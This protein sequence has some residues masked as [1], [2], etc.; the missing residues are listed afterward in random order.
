[1]PERPQR[2]RKGAADFVPFDGQVVERR[3]TPGG[4][5]Y[6]RITLGTAGGSAGE[7][8]DPSTVIDAEFLFLPGLWW[9]WGWGGWCALVC[10][11]VGV[12]G[13]KEWVGG[14]VG[15]T[16]GVRVR[17]G[18]G[19]HW[20]AGSRAATCVS[21]LHLSPAPPP[22]PDDNIV[23]VRAASRVEPEGGLGSGGQLALS[24]TEGLVL[25]RCAA[26][27]AAAPRSSPPGRPPL[28]RRRQQGRGQARVPGGAPP[29]AGGCSGVGM[30]AC[31][32]QPPPALGALGPPQL[33]R[34]V[35]RRQMERLRTALRWEPVP[36]IADFNPAFNSG[37][38]G[39][40]WGLA[41][42]GQA[43]P[44][45]AATGWAAGRGSAGARCVTDARPVCLP[46]PCLVQ[47]PRCGLSAC[48]TPSTAATTSSP[49]GW[50]TPQ[51]AG[52]E[53]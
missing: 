21:R 8:A 50:H 34:N 18:S 32:A 4:A 25:D 46:T 1:M 45:G 49:A 12:W 22:P 40:M 24:F 16:G 31:P 30:P 52:A 36:V 26:A 53:R 15:T 20:R 38:Q 48:S 11:S 41:G 23:D 27:A 13:R 3:T 7:V 39:W 19:R 14:W 28:G 33:C 37:E 47:R 51:R 6:V 5:E 29:A 2:Q 9:W 42:L 17:L 43:C 35:A 44:L 10:G